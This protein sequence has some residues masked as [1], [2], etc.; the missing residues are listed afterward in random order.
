MSGLATAAA[1]CSRRKPGKGFA[2]YAFVANSGGAA[3]AAVDLTAFV[4]ARHIA[5]D[6]N[7]QQVLG[8]PEWPSIYAIAPDKSAVF[9]IDAEKLAVKARRKLNSTPGWAYTDTVSGRIWVLAKS[10]AEITSLKPDDLSTDRTVSLP[11]PAVDLDQAPADS[12]AAGL[13]ATSTGDAGEVVL[14]RSI[15]GKVDRRIK[16]G[17]RLGIVRFRRDGRHLLVGNRADHE[18]IVFDLR[19]NRVAVRLPLAVQPDRCCMK[20]DGGQ[21]FV[22]GDGTEAVVTVY[23]YQTEVGSITLAGR[24]PGYLTASQAPDYLFVANP[25]TNGVTVI[26]IATQKVMAVAT[27]GK[28]PSFIAVTPNNEYALVLNRDSGD[29]AVLHFGSMTAR[30]TKS[31]PLLNMI[32]VGSQP[33]SAVVR[34]I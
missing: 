33:V 18:M 1:A 9:A 7:P 34:A 5:I 12:P 27:V 15:D 13:I 2:G 31:I 20:G 8:T 10:A 21:M 3:V 16:L 29:M 25:E 6:G 19:S 14:L 22:A 11:Q 24:A 23:P 26:N 28:A 17:G 4:V 30:R 32:P